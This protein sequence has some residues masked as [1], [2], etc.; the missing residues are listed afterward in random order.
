MPTF[1]VMDIKALVKEVEELV[2]PLLD[3]ENVELVEILYRRESGRMVLRFLVDVPGGIT[4]AECARLNNQIGKVLDESNIALAN[5]LL[6]VSSPGLDRP[7]KT[8]KDFLRAVGKNVRLLYSK[9]GREKVTYIGEVKS[10]DNENVTLVIEGKEEVIP[11]DKIVKA[12]LEI[13]GI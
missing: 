13:E 5:Y 10:V 1:F 2:S 12:R 3:K 6:E 7:I 11:I 8:V 4:L 9:D